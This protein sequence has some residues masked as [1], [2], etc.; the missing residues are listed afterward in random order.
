LTAVG[1]ISIWKSQERVEEERIHTSMSHRPALNV[2]IGEADIAAFRGGLTGESF[3]F[4]KALSL[5]L[6]VGD[7]EARLYQLLHVI[8]SLRAVALSR[9]TRNENRESSLQNLRRPTTQQ[10]TAQHPSIGSPRRCRQLWKQPGLRVKRRPSASR[11]ERFLI[12]PKRQRS[13]TLQRMRFNQR[14]WVRLHLRA[15][16]TPKLQ[17]PVVCANAVLQGRRKPSAVLNSS[18]SWRIEDDI[19]NIAS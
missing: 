6:Q 1:G 10:R 17:F 19:V 15:L 7:R 2:M 13:G 11:R 14:R 4:T 9:T 16:E 3:L 12:I 18:G 8:S 5:E